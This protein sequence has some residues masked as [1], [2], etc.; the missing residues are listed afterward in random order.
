MGEKI[1]VYINEKAKEKHKDTLNKKKK[2]QRCPE[3]ELLQYREDYKGTVIT[4]KID[5][6]DNNKNNYSGGTKD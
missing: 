5:L 3:C 4:T 1:T 6:E 2:K